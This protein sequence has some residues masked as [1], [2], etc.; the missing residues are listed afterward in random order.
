MSQNY[1]LSYLQEVSKGN[2]PFML[3]MIQ[4][5]LTKTPETLEILHQEIEKSNWEMVGF[6]AHK[7]KA[8][9]AYMGMNDLKEILIK[10]WEIQ[11][12]LDYPELLDDIN[13]KSNIDIEF[14]GTNLFHEWKK[15]NRNTC[16]VS[17]NL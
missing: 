11:M 17:S 16:L 5:F 8:T 1:N 9:Y 12:I 6:F 3:D 7:L 13:F 10:P 4:I 14:N 15:L 2:I